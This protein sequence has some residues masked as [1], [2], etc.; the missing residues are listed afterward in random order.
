MSSDSFQPGC[1]PDP[2][3]INAYYSTDEAAT[4]ACCSSS[5][6]ITTSSPPVDI[7]LSWPPDVKSS[8]D[9]IRDLL[10][11][12]SLDDVTGLIT[13]TPFFKQTTENSEQLLG[14]RI[15]SFATKTSLHVYFVDHFAK[16]L[17]FLIILALF[18]QPF[19]ISTRMFCRVFLPQRVYLLRGTSVYGFEKEVLAK[20]NDKGTHVYRNVSVTQS[21]RSK[22]K[23]N[24]RIIFHPEST[25]L[26]L[27]C[28]E[29][30]S[31]ARRSVLDPP[32][33][34]LNLIPGDVLWTDPTMQPGLSPDKERGIG[35]ILIIRSHEGPDAREKR[36]GLAG[37]DEGKKMRTLVSLLKLILEEVE[38]KRFCERLFYDYE[39]V[40][41]YDEELDSLR[42]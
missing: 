4:I 33:E 17:R 10:A 12:L 15:L 29:E 30:L 11:L 35:L 25:P 42:W 19:G 27:G 37:V 40:I 32:W 2:N 14:H 26:S 8:L 18:K 28:F 41:D 5:S 13:S 7:P 16:A 20:Y 36:S 23:K 31:K 24:R 3:P 34:G 38:R 21:K 22:G 39:D 9:W 6:T 1:P